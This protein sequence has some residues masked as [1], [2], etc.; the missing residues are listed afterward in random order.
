MAKMGCSTILALVVALLCQMTQYALGAEVPASL[1]L[2]LRA[3]IWAQQLGALMNKGVSISDPDLKVAGTPAYDKCHAAL[4]MADSKSA[5]IAN[6]RNL[7]AVT[8]GY[9][10]QLI[11]SGV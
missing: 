10:A 4:V 11:C 2:T 9:A 3:N 5:Q 1:V 8:I 6:Q 7:P